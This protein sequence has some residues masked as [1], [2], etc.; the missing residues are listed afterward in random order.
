MVENKNSSY[1]KK[2]RERLL[3]S[4]I[5][6]LVLFFGTL[7]AIYVFLFYKSIQPY[8]FNPTW[9]TDDALQQTFPFYKTLYPNIFQ[10]DLPTQMMESYLTPLHYWITYFITLLTNDPIIAG[11]WV[12]LIQLF[13]TILFLFLAIRSSVGLAPA[14]FSVVWFLHTRH[15][16]Q[17]LTAGL[18]RGWSA[19]I[20]SCFIYLHVSKKHKA[21]HAFF[22]A[23][24]ILHPPST[25]V[26][27]ISYGIYLLFSVFPKKTRKENIKH[28]R[29]LIIGAPVYAFLTLSVIGMRPEIGEMASYEKAVNMPEFSRRS[30]ISPGGRFPFTP[31]TPV[32]NEVKTFGFQS[33]LSRFFSPPT[34]IKK[35]MPLIVIGLSI[36]AFFYL[37]FKK[38]DYALKFASFLLGI[39][40]VYSLSRIFA[41]K[42]YVPDRHLQFPL[43]FFFI[44]F[45]STAAGCLSTRS[46]T[47]LVKPSIFYNICLSILLAFISVVIAYQLGFKPRI[48]GVGKGGGVLEVSFIVAAAVSL[49]LYL[50]SFVR[51]LKDL[52]LFENYRLLSH[53]NRLTWLA[54]TFLCL[55]V[56]IGSND[57]FAGSANFNMTNT[58]RGGTY[59]WLRTH[60]DENA[61]IAG[62]PTFVDGVPLYAV[63]KVYINTEMAHPFYDRYYESIKP[64]IE[65]S[66]RANYAKDYEEFLRLVAPE[67]ID[68]FVFD[69]S[70]FS[71]EALKSAKY[72]EPFFELVKE[73]ASKD[74][75]DYMYQKLPKKVDLQNFPFVPYIDEKGLVVDVKKLQTFLNNQINANN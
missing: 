30:A 52:P 65:V 42:L 4:T 35:T 68:Y 48:G 6:P 21:I 62:H 20:L 14:F 27:G 60:S 28:L 7:T 19:P 13:L 51:A 37:F 59:T 70:L 34:P 38:R 73:L 29:N 23:G 58:K 22:L 5:D 36:G 44:A 12:M 75:K 50:L 74:L 49:I 53:Q 63:R 15:I 43:A 57:G 40:I 69:R 55:L 56:Y 11:H 41:F 31:L 72:F 66:L 54:L 46:K 24:C 17:R 47:L 64:R 1:L 61:L 33:F 18:P 26:C 16:V 45:F 3:N 9:T 8:L 25:F 39:I 2:S 67:G 32:I 71:A 10:N